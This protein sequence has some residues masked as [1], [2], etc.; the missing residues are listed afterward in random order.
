[1]NNL[2]TSLL[3][4]EINSLGMGYRALNLATQ[5]STIRVLEAAPAADRFLIL[6]LST[7]QKLHE[8]LKNIRQTVDGA[9]AAEI[10]DWEIVEKIDPGVLEGIY[11]LTQNE[12]GESLIVAECAT[13]S[14]LLSV[15]Q[16]LTMDGGLKLIE[17][18]IK[19]AAPGGAWGFFTGSTAEAEPAAEKIRTLFQTKMRKGKIDVITAP[20]ES[21]RSFFNFSGKA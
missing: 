3:C 12:L 20:N 7:S 19:R 11:S 10:L 9:G 5:E 18:K 4:L 17:L 14:S 13:V 6:L 15:A 16:A 8:V 2:D 21:F 1:M